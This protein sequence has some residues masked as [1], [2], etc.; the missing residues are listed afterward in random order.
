[1]RVRLLSREDEDQVAS[2]DEAS[3]FYVGQWIE[4]NEDYA[5]GLFD[6]DTLIGYCTIGEASDVCEEICGDKDYDDDSLILSDVYIT[7]EYR[8]QGNAL[9]MLQE[10]L[11]IRVHTETI[12]CEPRYESLQRLYKKVGFI[13]SLGHAMKRNYKENAYVS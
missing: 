7:P 1:M 8:G 3:G 9:K 5:Y 11:S 13:K 2:M 6:K 10:T 4:D 12:Y